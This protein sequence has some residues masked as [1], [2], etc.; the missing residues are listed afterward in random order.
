MT[1]LF[2]LSWRDVLVWQRL[3]AVLCAQGHWW[4][5]ASNMSSSLTLPRGVQVVWLQTEGREP[6]PPVSCSCVLWDFKTPQNALS[7]LY[8]WDLFGSKLSFWVTCLSWR[9]FRCFSIMY[10]CWMLLRRSLSWSWIFPLE[11]ACSFLPS[12]TKRFFIW[13]PLILLME[14]AVAPHSSTVAWKIPWTEDPGGPQSM[15]SLR[16]RTWL[17]DFNFT[18][19]VHALEKEM[20]THSSALLPE[21]PRDGRAWWAAIYGV[22]QSQTR[23]K[24]LSSS[25]SWS[26]TVVCL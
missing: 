11:M 20:A 10:L 23:L 21:N 19:H 22:A 15:G 25:S 8:I 17:S 14:K 18:F 16:S 24:R 4:E 9:I 2:C 13:S 7:Y 3:C 1:Q 6:E 5:S 26:W 12:V